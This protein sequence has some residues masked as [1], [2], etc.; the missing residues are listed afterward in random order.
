[1]AVF[2]FLPMALVS[3]DVTA[4][5]ASSATF[6][7]P[8]DLPVVMAVD[9]LA[10]LLLFMSIFMYRNTRR[11]RTLTLLS[12]LLIVITM[13]TE[14]LVIFNWDGDISLLGSIFLLLGALVFALLAYRGI[15][16][17]ENLLKAADR[18]R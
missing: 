15:R 3:G 12:M 18:L 7:M 13:V 11:Q 8:G 2:C 9:I 17:D 10:A 16:H 14:G 5:E 6:L 1:M 4:A